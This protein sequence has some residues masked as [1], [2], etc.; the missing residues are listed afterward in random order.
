MENFAGADLHKKVT[1]LG[2]LRI[3]GYLLSPQSPLR[4]SLASR[5]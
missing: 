3:S 4:C 1:Q 5:S 2:L